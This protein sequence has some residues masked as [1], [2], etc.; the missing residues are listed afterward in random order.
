MERPFFP[1]EVEARRELARIGLISKHHYHTQMIQFDLLDDPRWQAN[2]EEKQSRFQ[3]DRYRPFAF[4]HGSLVYNPRDYN[5]SPSATDNPWANCP[6][7]TN[8]R[9]LISCHPHTRMVT[10]INKHHSHL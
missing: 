2:I 3:L 6:G 8:P 10:T 1:T 5:W 7:K 4:Q 9:T